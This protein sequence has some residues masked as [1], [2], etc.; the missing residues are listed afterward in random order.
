MEIGNE[1][2]IHASDKFNH[3][4]LILE[5]FLPVINY[6][7]N[8]NIDIDLKIY[9]HKKHMHK[10]DLLGIP[11]KY[12]INNEFYSK[13]H[14]YVFAN[15]GIGNPSCYENY[16][17]LMYGHGDENFIYNQ[18]MICR[19]KSYRGIICYSNYD[20]YKFSF[21]NTFRKHRLLNIGSIKFSNEIITDTYL[22]TKLIDYLTS[23]GYDK[24]KPTII[25]QHTRDKSNHSNKIINCSGYIG[26]SELIRNKLIELSD[27]FNIINK[28]HCYEDDQSQHYVD[29]LI[30][31]EAGEVPN[32]LLY[33]LSNLVISD[34]GGS[35]TDALFS[36]GDLL[37][38]NSETDYLSNKELSQNIDI[39]IHEDFNSVTEKE[40][41]DLDITSLSTSEIIKDKYKKL[42]YG[43]DYS[44]NSHLRFIR[45]L[46]SLSNN[47]KE[48]EYDY[49]GSLLSYE[50]DIARSLNLLGRQP[51]KAR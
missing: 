29:K 16:F 13:K 28:S 9:L 39:L 10:V 27:K 1:F 42:L 44:A 40:F 41:I 7:E 2:V 3:S 31:V 17:K 15:Y 12:I 43:Y 19:I 47:E 26:H 23:K 37:Y 46:E 24:N 36:E 22:N 33:K 48:S 21:N 11:R 30:N 5:T 51:K 34:Y 4:S 49:K 6:I 14:K 32:K 20:C 25:Y 38:I 35:T 45:L 18:S 8:N 50:E